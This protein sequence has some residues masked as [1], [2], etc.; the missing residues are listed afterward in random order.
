MCGTLRQSLVKTTSK[1]KR[2][3]VPLCIDREAHCISQELRGVYGA[4]KS[5]TFQTSSNPFRWT[6]CVRS[7][8]R[9]VISIM[10]IIKL[11]VC[12]RMSIALAQTPCSQSYAFLALNT[13][14]ARPTSATAPA[15]INFR[16]RMA[17]GPVPKNK[18]NVHVDW[19]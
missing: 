5:R 4:R 14:T 7:G 3:R 17:R 1:A 8:A 2:V 13:P 19:L 15:G 12:A 9:E 16:D 6:A 10:S 18:V 11:T